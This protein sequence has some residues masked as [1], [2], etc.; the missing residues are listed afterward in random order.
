MGN[1]LLASMVLFCSERSASCRCHRPG[2]CLAEWQ[3]AVNSGS[4]VQRGGDTMVLGGFNFSA[5]PL[6]LQDCEGVEVRHPSPS[7][8]V[9]VREMMSRIL[10]PA[11]G[12]CLLSHLINLNSVEHPSRSNVS[13]HLAFWLV[14]CV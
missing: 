10:A 3:S 13:L 6:F 4:L 12:I 11:L 9:K 8:A 7:A 2:T 14:G 1:I 5:L